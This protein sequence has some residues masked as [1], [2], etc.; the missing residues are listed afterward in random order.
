MKAHRLPVPA[1][2]APFVLALAAATS[3]CGYSAQPSARPAERDRV[4]VQAVKAAVADLESALEISGSLAPLS[5]VGVTAKIPGRL[6]HVAVR[7]G[8]RVSAGSTIARLERREVDA[9]VDAA[10][11]SVAVARAGLAAAEAALDNAGQEVTRARSLFEKGAL[12]RQRLDAAETAARAAAAQVDLAKA[13]VAQAEAAERRAHEV[14][15]DTTLVSPVAGVIVERNHDPGALVGR[16]EPPVAVVADISALRLEAGVSELDAGRLHVGAPVTVEVAARP[17]DRFAGRL[18]AIAPEVDARNRHFR[19]EVLVS[20]PRGEL[21]GGM[22]AVARIVTGTAPKALTVPREAVAARDG[23]QVVFRVVGETV[24]A[25][26]VDVG[27]SDVRRVQILSGLGE[28]DVVLAD[29]RHT[30]ADGT[31]VKA[32]LQ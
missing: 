6:E 11:A 17:G 20:N 31:R 2:L 19:I 5:R 32:I 23:R 8:D 24:R 18:T 4:A 15:R 21:L 13:T 27:L 28:G 29:A 22:Y 10:A 14:L 9:Q 25:V 12:P 16:G 26:P 3:G 30:V 7:L 1:L